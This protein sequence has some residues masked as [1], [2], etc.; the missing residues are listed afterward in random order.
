MATEDVLIVVYRETEG[1]KAILT[2]RLIK[3]PY[4][5]LRT[6]MSPTFKFKFS[7]IHIHNIANTL[8]VSDI[9]TWS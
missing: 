5:I 7:N 3:S 1:Y 8:E 6:L 2:P 9:L 4:M